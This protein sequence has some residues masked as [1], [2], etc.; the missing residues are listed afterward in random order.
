MS[1]FSHCFCRKCRQPEYACGCEEPDLLPPAID[2]VVRGEAP[3]PDH[4][5]LDGEDGRGGGQ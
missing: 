1:D 2:Y 4:P 5:W 3:P